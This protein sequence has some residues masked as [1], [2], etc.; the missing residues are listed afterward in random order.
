MVL[1]QLSDLT[2]LNWGS[3]VALPPA[4]VPLWNSDWCGTLLA[5][6]FL[7][8]YRRDLQ[9]RVLTEM[10]K[11][12]KAVNWGA[13]GQLLEVRTRVECLL[14]VALS[15]ELALQCPAPEQR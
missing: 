7:S 3:A 9:Q 5:V 8:G 4:P 6:A 13:F 15:Q 10:E 12:K 14:L 11:E 2:A 1:S